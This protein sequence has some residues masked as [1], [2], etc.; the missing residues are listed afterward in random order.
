MCDR[1][2]FTTMGK[3]VLGNIANFF[4]TTNKNIWADLETYQTHM[5]RET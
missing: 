1:A 4:K 2:F 5:F 3:H